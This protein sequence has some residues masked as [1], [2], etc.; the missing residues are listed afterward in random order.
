MADS[1]T[2]TSAADLPNVGSYPLNS[3][4]NTQLTQPRR[5]SKILAGA[6]D[7]T[8]EKLWDLVIHKEEFIQPHFLLWNSLIIVLVGFC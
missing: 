7:Y 3:K 4:G 8:Q 1:F 2:L 6:F 5:R